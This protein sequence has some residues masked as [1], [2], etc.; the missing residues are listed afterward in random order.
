MNQ[1]IQKSLI[2]YTNCKYYNV[3]LKSLY[4]ESAHKIADKLVNEFGVNKKYVFVCGLGGNAADGFAVAKCLSETNIKNIEVYV[5]GRLNLSEDL[6][7]KEL[8]QELTDYKDVNIKQDCYATDIPQGDVVVE[9]LVGTG[10]EGNKLNKRFH[11]VIKR[12]SHFNSILIAI[13]VP[14]P[15]YKPDKVYSLMYPKTEEAEVIDIKLPTDLNL[16]VGPGEVKYLFQPN[17][18]SHKKKNGKV[19]IVSSTFNTNKIINAIKIAEQY[20][21]YCYI[22]NFNKDNS[23]FKNF[24]S[25][26]YELVENKDVDE[27][28]DNCDVILYKDIDEANLLNR[29]V[30]HELANYRGRKHILNEKA[31]DFLHPREIRELN[32]KIIIGNKDSLDKFMDDSIK[33][34]RSISQNYNL[35]LVEPGLKT[36]IYSESG[37]IK[38]DSTGLF[39]KQEYRELLVNLIGMLSTK[40]DSLLSAQA[41]L[42]IVSLCYKLAS[43]EGDISIDNIASKIG[44][45]MEWCWE[46]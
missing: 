12:I 43:D 21:T 27:A 37:D 38:F 3:D 44:E 14:A 1:I 6:I 26:Y 39:F 30:V 4:E 8:F 18:T 9:C 23:Q 42:F 41:G 35:T 16:L 15:S 25:N 2:T 45:V 20:E 33:N 28:V 10:L 13:D 7:A 40:N 31:L 32:N 46:Y 24:K 5:V 34:I 19:L 36:S 29:S 11:D 17:K 22:Y